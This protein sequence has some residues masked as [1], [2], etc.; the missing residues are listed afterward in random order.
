MAQ[1]DGDGG[2]VESKVA[3]GKSIR[4]DKGMP[5]YRAD[6]P[7][8]SGTTSWIHPSTESKIDSRFDEDSKLRIKLGLLWFNMISTKSGMAMAWA[9]APQHMRVPGDVAQRNDDGRQQ[10]VNGNPGGA[11]VGIGTPELET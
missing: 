10:T 5:F 8:T 6:N 9:R 7:S 11:Q 2:G 1:K 4:E 3:V